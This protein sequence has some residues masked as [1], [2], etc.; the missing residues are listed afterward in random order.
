MGIAEDIFEWMLMELVKKGV[1]WSFDEGV[2]K[3]KRDIEDSKNRKFCDKAIDDFCKDAGIGVNN[4]IIKNLSP[5]M[6]EYVEKYMLNVRKEDILNSFKDF[7][8][9]SPYLNN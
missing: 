4:K 3:V 6:Q 8:F 9:G 7:K 5:A 2:K 1:A